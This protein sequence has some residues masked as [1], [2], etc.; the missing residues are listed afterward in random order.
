MPLPASDIIKTFGLAP[1]V[2]EAAVCLAGG[3]PKPEAHFQP[4]ILEAS[5]KRWKHGLGL[6]EI[7]T[8]FARRNGH[9]AYSLRDTEPVLR[10]AFHDSSAVLRASGVSNLSLPGILSNVANKFMRVGFDS[11]ESTWRGIA[12]IRPV[13][14][15][16]EVS[17][18]TLT[19]DFDYKEVPP[20]GKL[21]HA[22][23]GEQSYTNQAKTYG[24]LFGVDRR[25][26]INDDLNALTGVPRRLGRGG[27]LKFNDVFWTK[28]LANS[29][30]FTT[31]R[32]NYL[33]GVTPG[34]D[35]S[36]LNI[37]GLTRAETAFLNQTDPDGKPLGSMP[38][39][40]LVPNALN[41]LA[42]VL[43]SSTEIRDT[44]ANT[45]TPTGNPHAGKFT[46]VRSTYLS[47]PT[48]IGYSALAWYLLADP[49]DIA[50]IEA[51]FLNGA[52][53]PTVESADADFNQLGIQMRGW[54][55]FGVELQEY[56]GGVK[57]AGA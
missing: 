45:T 16:K 3:L 23:A 8:L 51:C 48:F 52:E 42:S 34:T 33:S 44:T 36:R 46:V 24:R 14:D 47:N 54:H 2:F 49:Q 55:D 39:I 9:D 15:F 5:R 11:V 31:P 21:E 40:L 19:G 30:F 20:G 53:A 25:D 29:G 12:A 50:V 37:E 41:T 22:Q 43:M 6:E 56:R 32:A 38:K 35:D 4:E 28:F 13:K 26:L 10:A 27:A 1:A 7:I 57:S 17:S 18:Y